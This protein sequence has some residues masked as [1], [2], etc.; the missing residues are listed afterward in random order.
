[1]CPSYTP[2]I[3]AIK[4]FVQ[5]GEHW[6]LW[7][8]IRWKTV[9]GILWLLD[10]VWRQMNTYVPNFSMFYALESANM[11]PYM[12]KGFCRCDHSEDLKMGK[13]SWITHADPLK[14]QGPFL[15][16]GRQE[17]QGQRRRCEDGSRGKRER[18]KDAL[19]GFKDGGRSHKSRN[20][21]GLYIMKKA[22]K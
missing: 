6:T 5:R 18:F 14:S 3:K 10:L 22:R 9:A 19:T 16:W 13:L 11:W 2:K 1:M 21:G 8:N 15:L 20:T 12:Q 7:M 17:G 4:W